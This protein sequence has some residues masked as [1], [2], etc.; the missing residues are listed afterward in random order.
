M[1]ARSPDLLLPLLASSSPVTLEQ[2]R[3][4][5]GEPFRTTF[6]YLSQ[7]HHL[8]SYNHNGRFF[9]ARDPACFDDLGLLR[10]GGVCFSRVTF[11]APLPES[12]G[13]AG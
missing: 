11:G 13:S 8:R 5:L 1:A 9:T 7:V 2:L 3:Q 6:R 12:G 10:L 4:A